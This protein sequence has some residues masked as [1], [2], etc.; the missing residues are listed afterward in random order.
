[1]W[2]S[3]VPGPMVA[4]G[5]EQELE[6]FQEKQKGHEFVDFSHKLL[7]F[8]AVIGPCEE[9]GEVEEGEDEEGRRKIHELLV[10]VIVVAVR[11]EI[12]GFEI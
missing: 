8:I 2:G 10:D 9:E 6:Q 7:V 11:F 12:V 4:A 1:M 3:S 5:I